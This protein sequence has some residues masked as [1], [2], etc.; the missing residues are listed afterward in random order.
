MSI[1]AQKPN[2]DFSITPAECSLGGVYID[3]TNPNN[4]GLKWFTKDECVNQLQ[5]IAFG[6]A[7]DGVRVEC[8]KDPKKNKGIGGSWTNICKKDLTS[9][10]ANY[11]ITPTIKL[12]DK[13]NSP[14]PMG[15]NVY[16]TSANNQYLKY[17]TPDE[18]KSKLNG[19]LGDISP[20]GVNYECHAPWTHTSYSD[21]CKITP[22]VY[23]CS[24]PCIAD[25]N[26]KWAP[27]PNPQNPRWNQ[28]YTAHQCTKILGGTLG[29][30]QN[31]PN[32]SGTAGALP[33]YE[34]I[35][36]DGGSYSKDC[37]FIPLPGSISITYGT[38]IYSP[39]TPDTSSQCK[40][41]QMIYQDKKARTC[42][43]PK[44]ITNPN[45]VITSID[46]CPDPSMNK[47]EDIFVCKDPD[48]DIVAARAAI[49]KQKQDLEIKPAAAVALT[50]SFEASNAAEAAQYRDENIDDMHTTKQELLGY[51]GSLSTMKNSPDVEKKKL[52][53]KNIT[54]THKRQVRHAKRL[55]KG[56]HYLMDIMDGPYQI[57]LDDSWV[58]SGNIVYQAVDDMT[59][60]PDDT[61]EN[62]NSIC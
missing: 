28:F 23:P 39:L 4:L 42:T 52:L 20:I 27:D 21:I 1:E 48:P 25:A 33:Y 57:P 62:V 15:I 45:G 24:T 40:L 22:Q 13:C 2:F 32:Y 51:L 12:V 61:S 59:S 19:I 41:P 11:D 56:F 7:P 46:S 37:A 34:C 5:G 30:M 50:T 36:P 54:E 8:M 31:I 60:G 53:H 47:T 44:T 17:Y 16:T 14:S 43:I 3:D 9:P 58:I 49:K 10:S 26:K 6:S 38:P 35:R 18:C 55:T 29:A